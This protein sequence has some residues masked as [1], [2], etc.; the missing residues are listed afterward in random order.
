M[1]D[2]PVVGLARDAGPRFV[3]DAARRAGPG[4]GP[5]CVIATGETTVRV[6]GRGR[7]GRN[8][9]AGAVGGA[10]ARGAAGVLRP[11]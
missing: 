3:E 6:T 7:G 5:V 1:V 4:D 10:D 2:E 9:E 8:Q 11:C